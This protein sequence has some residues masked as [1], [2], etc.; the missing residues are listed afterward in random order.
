MNRRLVTRLGPVAF[1]AALSACGNDDFENPDR[2][3]RHI[4]YL[5]GQIVE[6]QGLPAFS[7]RYGEYRFDD[8]VSSFEDAG[9]EVTAKVREAG[10][11]PAS[12]AEETVESILDILDRGV[13]PENI[14]VIGASKGA[15]IASLVSNQMVGPDIRVILLAGCSAP[16]SETFLADGMQFHGHILAIRDVSDTRLAGSCAGIAEQSPGLSSFQ[17]IV[18][19]TGLE[20]GLIYEPR[21]EWVVPAMDWAKAAI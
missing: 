20:H 19:D 18:T 11:D 7:E 6:D 16:V 10:A 5:H 21:E 9:F 15:Y 3:S 8:I 4:I 2:H 14:I 12:H 1:C 13:P 17:E